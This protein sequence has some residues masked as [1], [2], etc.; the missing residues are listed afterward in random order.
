VRAKNAEEKK[1]TSGNS[2]EKSKLKLY[3]KM[4]HIYDALYQHIFDYGAQAGLVDGILKRYGAESVL[5]LGCGSGH[6]TERLRDL[7]YKVIGADLNKEMLDI[8]R[9]RTRGI[10]FV[11]QDMRN[12]TIDD[13][14]DAVVIFGRSFTY[15]TTNKDALAALRSIYS[16]L[17]KGG[18]LIF[19]NFDAEK[20]LSYDQKKSKADEASAGDIY[21]KRTGSSRVVVDDGVCFEWTVK[22]EITECDKSYIE[23]DT[24]LL[25]SFFRSELE[26]LLECAGFHVKD[27]K[28][29]GTWLFTAQK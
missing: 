16:R 20:T 10:T 29:D 25:R 9:K 22:Y 17:R 19:D 28:K 11:E 6:L 3:T 26:L 4:A 5:E 15:M 27:V 21:I 18:V 14:F 8:A 12:I 7:G 13:K 1:M 2:T 23:E 24:Q